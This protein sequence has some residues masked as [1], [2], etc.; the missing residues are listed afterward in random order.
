MALPKEPDSNDAV[1]EV[2]VTAFLA[3]PEKA[4]EKI[5]EI[6]VQDEDLRDQVEGALLWEEREN[7]EYRPFSEYLKENA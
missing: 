4:R 2:F 7:G 6:L 1:A 3:L 5:I